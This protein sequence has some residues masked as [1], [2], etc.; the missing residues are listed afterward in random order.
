TRVLAQGDV[1]QL[2]G[3]RNGVDDIRL[4][5]ESRAGFYAK[6]DLTFNTSG[7]SL[8]DAFTGLLDLVQTHT[9]LA[10]TV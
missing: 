2:P 1:R 7:K 6:A 4:T 8:D 5:L 9:P 10:E 3:N